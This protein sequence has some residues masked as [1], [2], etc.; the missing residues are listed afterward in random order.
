MSVTSCIT[1][2][3]AANVSDGAQTAV[4]SAENLVRFAFQGR[5]GPA[6]IAP[7]S[8]ARRS[9][10]AMKLPPSGR[11]DRHFSRLRA[12]IL[13]ANA[14]MESENFGRRLEPA[15]ARFHTR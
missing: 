1:A 5:P 12:S 8:T 3:S 15:M 10:S 6:A 11:P 9:S 14:A 7:A 4:R 13:A 2:I